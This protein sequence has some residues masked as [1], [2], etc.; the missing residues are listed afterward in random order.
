MNKSKLLAASLA[1]S[2]GLAS[3]ACFAQT[4]TQ[5]LNNTYL[6]FTVGQSSTRLESG[7][8]R[9]FAGTTSTDDKTDT[10]F[11]AYIGY[12]FTD[13]WAAEA[14]YA[15]FG[16]ASRRFT[17]PTGTAQSNIDN[18]AYYLEGKGTLPLGGAFG[19]FGKLGLSNNVSKLTY[20]TG[21]PGDTS[22]NASDHRT[23]MIWGIGAEWR[24]L[25]NV[26]VVAEYEDFG[27]FGNELGVCTGTCFT[28]RSRTSM[29]SVGLNFTL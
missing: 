2:L 3:S 4:T 18:T 24:W 6:G 19:L 5:L 17:A 12:R 23:G 14:G 9:G 25:R 15:N 10:A 7:D 8:F 26:S 11:K 28:G 21:I 29:F 13:I 20:Q 27:K 16:T 22:G 1:A